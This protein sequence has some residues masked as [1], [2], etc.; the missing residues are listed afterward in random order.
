MPTACVRSF[1]RVRCKTATQRSSDQRP[2]NRFKALRV[3]NVQMYDVR[4]KFKLTLLQT[5]KR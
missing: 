1:G 3:F 4:L 5:Q 2:F